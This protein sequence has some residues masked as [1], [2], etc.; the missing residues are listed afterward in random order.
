M[1]GVGCYSL[2]LDTRFHAAGLSPATVAAVR[3]KMRPV[4]EKIGLLSPS[5]AWPIDW[6][7]MGIEAEHGHPQ[8]DAGA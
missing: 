6:E 8:D 2:V 1:N 4:L 7:G 3:G 5:G